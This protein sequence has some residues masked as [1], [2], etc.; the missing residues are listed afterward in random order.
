MTGYTV[1][2]LNEN[3]QL[4]ERFQQHFNSLS[5]YWDCDRVLL[6][7][8]MEPQPCQDFAKEIDRQV[9]K[10]RQ[11]FSLNSFI[12]YL[13]TMSAYLNFMSQTKQTHNPLDQLRD[14]FSQIDPN[15]ARQPDSP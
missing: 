7:N 5:N 9:F 1:I 8:Q 4:Q 12:A 3:Q 14:D 10:E 6:D 11:V 13:S 2:E 15:L